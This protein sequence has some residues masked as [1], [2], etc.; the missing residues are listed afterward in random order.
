MLCLQAPGRGQGIDQGVGGS[1]DMTHYSKLEG[2]VLRRESSELAFLFI[3]HSLVR[4][5]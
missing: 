5:L 4:Q 3:P 2:P 1:T